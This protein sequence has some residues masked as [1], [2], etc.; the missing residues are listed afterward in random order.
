MSLSNC[1]CFLSLLTYNKKQHTH[2]QLLHP[3]PTLTAQPVPY[4]HPIPVRPLG[5]L[6]VHR[7]KHCNSP[8]CIPIRI[9]SPLLCQTPWMFHFNTGPRP[10]G[11]APGPRPCGSRHGVPFQHELCSRVS[12]LAYLFAYLF[13]YHLHTCVHTCLDTC[14]HTC[15]HTMVLLSQTPWMFQFNTGSPCGLRP[16]STQSRIASCVS[17]GVSVSTRIVFRIFV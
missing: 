4:T 17:L 6:W 8:N 10:A 13:A 12:T 15:L 14:V 5:P 2:P 9:P 3:R 7:V 16:R 1:F 11:F